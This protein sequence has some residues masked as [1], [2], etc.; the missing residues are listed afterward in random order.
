VPNTFAAV[1]TSSLGCGVLEADFCSC[2]DSYRE[3]LSAIDNDLEELPYVN[4]ECKDDSDWVLQ[5][6]EHASIVYIEDFFTDGRDFAYYIIGRQNV[7]AFQAGMFGMQAYNGPICATPIMSYDRSI[8]EANKNTK[9]GGGL[10]KRSHGQMERVKWK[11]LFETARLAWSKLLISPQKLHIIRSRNARI[12]QDRTQA[13]RQDHVWEV[14]S[15]TSTEARETESGMDTWRHNRLYPVVKELASPGGAPHGHARDGQPVTVPTVKDVGWKV[16]LNRMRSL[17]EDIKKQDPGT[18]NAIDHLEEFTRNQYGDL[19]RRQ[20]TDGKW[21]RWTERFQNAVRNEF[22]IEQMLEL[23]D[24]AKLPDISP[25]K[26]ELLGIL[27]QIKKGREG[28]L[29]DIVNFSRH[30]RGLPIQE[31][32]ILNV[33]DLDDEHSEL[34]EQLAG[35]TGRSKESALRLLVQ[36]HWDVQDAASAHFD[37]VDSIQEAVPGEMTEDEIANAI[38]ASSEG[39]PKDE[40]DLACRDSALSPIASASSG[41]EKHRRMRWALNH[42]VAGPSHVANLPK[43]TTEEEEAELKAAR[44]WVTRLILE[45][46]E[47]EKYGDEDDEAISPGSEY[48]ACQIETCVILGINRLHIDICLEESGQ[49]A[50]APFKTPRLNAVDAESTQPAKLPSLQTA[51]DVIGS[52]PTRKRRDS[53]DG[54]GSP[55]KK[56]RGSSVVSASK[57]ENEV[58]FVR[59][60][61]P[62]PE[63]SIPGGIGD[64]PQTS[65]LYFSPKGK[66]LEFEDKLVI[67]RSSGL[68]NDKRCYEV[69]FEQGGNVERAINVLQSE[70]KTT[71]TIA[72]RQTQT[73]VIQAECINTNKTK[74]IALRDMGFMDDKQNAHALNKCYGSVEEAVEFLVGSMNLSSPPPR[75]EAESPSQVGAGSSSQVA[76]DKENEPLHEPEPKSKSSKVGEYLR[77]HAQRL[78][79]TT[80]PGSRD[81]Y[82][83]PGLKDS[84]L[85]ESQTESESKDKED[86]KDSGWDSER[87]A[88]EGLPKQYYTGKGKGKA[89]PGVEYMEK[90]ADFVET[91]DEQPKIDYKGEGKGRADEMMDVDEG[92]SFTIY[93]DDQPGK[94]DKGKGRARTDESTAIKSTIRFVGYAEGGVDDILDNNPLQDTVVEQDAEGEDE[95]DT[96]GTQVVDADGEDDNEMETGPSA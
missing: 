24:I 70:A 49:K 89:L 1:R 44:K 35:I 9:Y 79:A 48:I 77:E 29:I 78:Q 86:R 39:L 10:V 27:T 85:A 54:S 41:G 37:S 87:R 19:G 6:N 13:A 84:A 46:E 95:A 66:E 22:D 30:Q 36:N 62:A 32:E 51:L 8:L 82:V 28:T 65:V 5:D 96:L 3:I 20:D 72:P 88:S 21:K 11:Y 38:L 55:P 76:P 12:L 45:N 90:K 53:S 83:L 2:R 52:N 67:L 23:P 93:E 61:N 16:E 31:V 91:Q 63:Q 56:Q 58:R 40:H 42:T 47:E 64:T 81:K 57:E 50:S 14:Q 17:F 68:A 60:G 73:N 94:D 26:A 4:K 69:L 34:L 75:V 18:G 43:L 80:A 74:L 92:A 59:E 25:A 71:A 33:E 15:V 7:T